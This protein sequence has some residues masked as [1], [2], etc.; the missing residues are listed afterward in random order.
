MFRGLHTINLDAKGRLAIPTK[1]RDALA[2]LCGGRLV[3]TID[4]EEHCLLIYPVNEWEPIQAQ[5]EALPSFNPAA[6]RIQR[7]LIGHATD[8]ELDGSVTISASRHGAESL[9]SSVTP[10]GSR[11]SASCA[12]A[13]HSMRPPAASHTSLP[14]IP[15]SEC[16]MERESSGWPVQHACHDA[17]ARTSRCRTA[18]ILERD[19]RERVMVVHRNH[20]LVLRRVVAHR[21]RARNA[22]RDDLRLL[23]R[24]NPRHAA[25]AHAAHVLGPV[26]EDHESVVA[27][28]RRVLGAHELAVRI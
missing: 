14:L 12:E 11:L 7:L 5:I 28:L 27:A 19:E 1:H 26:L 15:L 21:S 20:E 6:R 13:A 4:T 18:S 24:T 10:S 2:A 22:R 3:A 16:F 9:P 25:E 8:L 17:S 23:A